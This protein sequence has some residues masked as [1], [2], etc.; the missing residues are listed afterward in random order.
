M[1]FWSPDTLSVME[2]LLASTTFLARVRPLEWI[3]DDLS[4]MMRSPSSHLSPVM[5][6]SFS[7]YPRHVPERSTPLIISGRTAISPPTISM[8]ESSAP[9]WRPFPISSVISGLG[10]SMAM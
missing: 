10:L 9:F 2:M 5:I 8:L 7:T 3:P 1:L 6:L 4:E